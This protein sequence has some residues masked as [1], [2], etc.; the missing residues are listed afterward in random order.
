MI[1]PLAKK[2][3]CA[4]YSPLSEELELIHKP[5][6]FQVA[7]RARITKYENIFSKGNI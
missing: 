5:P 6:E 2:S 3:I 7:G 1:V 4:D